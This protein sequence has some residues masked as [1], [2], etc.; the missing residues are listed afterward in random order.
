M[1]VEP[2]GGSTS[3]D[4]WP[5]IV[6]HSGS[7]IPLQD[8]DPSHP[9]SGSGLLTTMYGH[10]AGAYGKWDQHPSL[11]RAVSI[12]IIIASQCQCQFVT[13]EPGERYT[14]ATRVRVAMGRELRP[15]EQRLE[16]CQ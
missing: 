4:T 12:R 5:Y 7:T 3:G 1:R 13:V 15:P 14:I 11:C 6:V 16:W 9:G 8:Q 10:G 2:T